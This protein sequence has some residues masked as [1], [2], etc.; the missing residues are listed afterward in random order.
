MGD[1]GGSHDEVTWA[2]TTREGC[3]V[4]CLCECRTTSLHIRTLLYMKRIC[5]HSLGEYL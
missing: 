2:D 3:V 4:R 1:S 5:C